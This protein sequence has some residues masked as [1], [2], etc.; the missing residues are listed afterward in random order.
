MTYIWQEAHWPEFTYNNT[1]LLLSTLYQYSQAIGQLTAKLEKIPPDSRIDAVI[2]LMVKEA[3]TTSAIE[4]EKLSQNDV[5][6]S[7]KNH[8]GLLYPPIHIRDPRAQGISALM[9]NNYQN[10]TLPLNEEILFRWHRMLL[11]NEYDTWGRKL[12]I[13]QWRSEG[14]QVISGPPH[15]QK[16]HFEAPPADQV[17][18]QMEQF[19]GWFNQTNPMHL[20]DKSEFIPGPIRAAI[21]HLWFVT[22]HPFDDGNGRLARA[23]SDY[24][25][26]QD[27]R[28]P[29]LHSL[30]AAIERKRKE[31][32]D[33]L[34]NT[35]KHSVD[36]SEWIDW[37]IGITCESVEI[38]KSIIAFTVQKSQ[39]IDKHRKSLNERQLQ[40]VLDLFSN[41]AEGDSKSVNRNK[42]VKQVH[43]SPRTALRDLNDLVNKAVL[44]QLPGQGRN[45]RYGLNISWV[46]I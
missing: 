35:Q 34:E 44:V 40:V 30:S 11:P 18:S 32:Y 36:I 24:A 33:K 28:Y 13:G 39:F 2:D 22:I 37:F 27:A 5:R 4:G 20:L 1:P 9:V 38:T 3:I 17:P 7:L 26:A 45:T 15:K 23:I 31:Y 10:H 46:A 19:F 25:L 43:C 16:V 12:H 21:A 29:M 41:G 42:Y 6:S 14:I 8:L